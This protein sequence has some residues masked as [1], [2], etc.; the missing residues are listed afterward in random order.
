MEIHHERMS[1]QTDLRAIIH[2]IFQ[3]QTSSFKFNF[4]FGFI[5]KNTKTGEVR[6]FYPSQNGFVFDETVL[7]QNRPDLDNLLTEIGNTDWL[8]WIRNQKPN[9]KWRIALTCCVAIHI[10]KISDLLVLLL[11]LL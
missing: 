6:Y 10:Y 5:L 8:E 9:S 7:I 2:R 11:L 3:Q 4:T 1:P